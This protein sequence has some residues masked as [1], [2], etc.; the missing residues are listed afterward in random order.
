MSD[1]DQVIDIKEH[2]AKN[3]PSVKYADRFR[4]QDSAM[5]NSEFSF[6]ANRP[7][8]LTV[9]DKTSRPSEDGQKGLYSISSLR[10]RLKGLMV[11]ASDGAELMSQ[12]RA[13][14]H[15]RSKTSLIPSMTHEGSLPQILEASASVAF[16][17]SMHPD[18]EHEASSLLVES[19]SRSQ[20]SRNLAGQLTKKPSFK[21]PP[22]PIRTFEH[23]HKRSKTT[24]GTNNIENY[25]DGKNS[26]SPVSS[27][28]G[29][30]ALGPSQ[31][32]SVWKSGL[33]IDSL[34]TD[35]EQSKFGLSLSRHSRSQSY[36]TLGSKSRGLHQRAQ[37]FLT[38]DR[39]VFD[40]S[41]ATYIKRKKEHETAL[42]NSLVTSSRAREAQRQRLKVN[43]DLLAELKSLLAQRR[44][45]DP[46]VLA[47]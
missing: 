46:L 20:F 32:H 15:E 16:S 19:P 22:I 10:E 14:M 31:D 42:K 7:K 35:H 18:A 4:V 5:P 11:A 27:R 13:T 23:Q 34:K 47:V 41:V 29:N 24:D 39:G 40:P 12:R 8:R 17:H 30:L 38:N 45:G 33:G 2:G 44:S 21:L 9:I 3:A 43:G 36:A 26:I 37:S 1:H 25:Y 6:A 28:P